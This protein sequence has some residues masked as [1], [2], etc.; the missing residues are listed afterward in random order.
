MTK[1][2]LLEQFAD[3]FSA[4]AL[5]SLHYD[6]YNIISHHLN[7]LAQ[8]THFGIPIWAPYISPTRGGPIDISKVSLGQEAAKILTLF[9]YLSFRHI[10]HIFSHTF[11]K[12]F[13]Y[14]QAAPSKLTI[15]ICLLFWSLAQ[16][17]DPLRGF[18]ISNQS[19]Q[20]RLHHSILFTTVNY[21]RQTI[22]IKFFMSKAVSFWDQSCA[23]MAVLRCAAWCK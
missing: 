23:V 4:W 14:L 7:Y 19:T 2:K 12:Y 5:L 16:V 21:F 1:R 15:I 3:M 9:I 22:L 18:H 6:I 13:F 10:R 17:A 20:L 11:S 8:P